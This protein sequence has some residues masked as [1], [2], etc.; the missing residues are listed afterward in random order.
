[1]NYFGIYA[2]HLLK[3]K[4]NKLILNDGIRFQVVDLHSTIAD[5]SF[6][7][8]P[9]TDIKQTTFAVTGNLGLVYLPTEDFRLTLGLSSGFRN[10]N[11]DDLARVFESG[12]AL[13]RVIVPNPDIK[14]EYTY[15]LDLGLTQMISGK[16]K[17][18]LTGF[19]TLFKNAIVLAPYQLNGEDSIL[20]NG[21]MCAVYANRNFK[22]ASLYGFNTNITVDFTK[23]LTF[24]GTV[25]YT[26]GRF[27]NSN[28]TKTPQDHIPPVFGKGSL[29]YNHP[30]FET[31]AYV[32]FNGMKKIKD[33]NP[34]GEDNQQYATPDGMPS[35]ATFNWR[36]SISIT[37]KTKVQFMIEN[38]LDRNYR[39]FAS[40]FSAAGRNY[41]IAL[42]TGF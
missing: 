9:V 19:Y 13:R 12:T 27:K 18:D 33:Y 23:Q 21:V 14:P 41:V 7:N 39:Y 31:E 20:Y 8:L 38:I 40:G 42:R 30:R 4:S 34:D 17:F 26:Y 6:F 11:I 36:N 5:N 1:M 24:F 32:L 25:T 10:P 3:L 22:E 37:K 35:W 2:Q 28:G 16:I 29:K 15:N